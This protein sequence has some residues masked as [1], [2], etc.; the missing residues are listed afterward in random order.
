MRRRKSLSEKLWSKVNRCGPNDCWL[1]TGWTKAARKG[2]PEYGRIN[3][4]VGAHGENKHIDLFAHRVAYELEVGKVPDKL[5]VRHS[6]HNPLCC[7]PNHLAVGTHQDNMDDMVK[8]GRQT[9]GECNG[10]SLLTW[11]DVHQIRAMRIEGQTLKEIASM[12]PVGIATVGL[13]CQNKIWKD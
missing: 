6:C 9:K 8:A 12:F 1:W 3:V 7:N 5:V 13:I 2:A 10:R 4:R 11:K